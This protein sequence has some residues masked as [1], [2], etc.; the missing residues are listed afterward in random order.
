MMYGF[1]DDENPL[2][3]TVD[4]TEVSNDESC[5]MFAKVSQLANRVVILLRPLPK[6]PGTCY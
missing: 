5:F 4:L 6:S 2:A 3:E 1:G